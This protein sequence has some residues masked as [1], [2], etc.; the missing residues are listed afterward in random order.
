MRGRTNEHGE[1]TGLVPSSAP[2]LGSLHVET[3]G[4]LP[5]RPRFLRN[6]A[7]RGSPPAQRPSRV[8]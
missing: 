6:A 1:A 5:S 7:G 8:C 2:A 4:F 3:L